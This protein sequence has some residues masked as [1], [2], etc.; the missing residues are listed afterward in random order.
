MADTKIK[1]ITKRRVIKFSPF[2]SS[3]NFIEPNSSITQIFLLNCKG[4]Q[5]IAGYLIVIAIAGVHKNHSAS[6]GCAGAVQRTAPG[7]NLINS[8]E[9]AQGVVIPQDMAVLA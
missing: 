4:Q 7:W 9:V 8:G 6:H 1:A 5:H 3:G 2:G